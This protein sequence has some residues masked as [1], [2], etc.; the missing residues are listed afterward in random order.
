MNLRNMIAPR[1]GVPYD[2][3]KEGR[4]KVFGN[5]GRF[6][7]SIPMDINDRSFGGEVMYQQQ[8]T[9]GQ[10]GDLPTNHPD[11][12]KIGGQNGQGCADQPEMVADTNEVMIGSSGVLVAPGIK[13]QY[14]DEILLGVEYELIEDLKV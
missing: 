7:E 2:W 8:F 6:Y 14:L 4:S 11:Y 1:V 12:V 13:P 10:C 3:T 9:P 5:W